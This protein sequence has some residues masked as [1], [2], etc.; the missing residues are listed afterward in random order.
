M[1]FGLRSSAVYCWLAAALEHSPNNTS[2]CMHA[3]TDIDRRTAESTAGQ[4]ARVCCR[5]PYGL[6]LSP[7]NRRRGF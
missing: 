3:V 4:Q 6:Q 2:Y 5:C 1:M 7:G